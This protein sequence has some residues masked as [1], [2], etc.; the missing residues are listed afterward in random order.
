MSSLRD[1]TMLLPHVPRSP[2]TLRSFHSRDVVERW[3]GGLGFRPP[4][5]IE[6]LAWPSYGDEP[7]SQGQNAVRVHR[8][9]LRFSTAKIMSIR[10]MSASVR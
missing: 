2:R 6:T 7:G 4:R 9:I 3:G 8:W 5:V 10:K 1:A